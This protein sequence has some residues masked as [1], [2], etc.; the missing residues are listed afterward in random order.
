MK[1]LTIFVVA[2]SMVLVF[3]VGTVFCQENQ[4]KK[5]VEL[6]FTTQGFQARYNSA[7]F[8]PNRFQIYFSPIVRADT[9]LVDTA[10]GMVWQMVEDTNT[11]KML[12]VYRDVDGIFE[13]TFLKFLEDRQLKEA[14]EKNK[15]QQ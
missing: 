8:Q 13:L 2:V 3:S 14:E 6:P 10:T 11:K 9:F 12:F 5:E 7:P 15:K 1:R 4:E